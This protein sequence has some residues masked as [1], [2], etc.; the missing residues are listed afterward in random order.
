[1]PRR[2]TARGP[3]LQVITA[4]KPGKCAE[5]S[6]D[7]VPGDK[8]TCVD[9]QFMHLECAPADPPAEAADGAQRQRDRRQAVS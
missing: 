7:V 1:M 9:L 5:C 4:R 3:R 6:L 2:R 8:I